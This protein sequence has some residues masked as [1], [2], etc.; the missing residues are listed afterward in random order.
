MSKS[1]HH[2]NIYTFTFLSKRAPKKPDNG[3][4]LKRHTPFWST[5]CLQ[6]HYLRQW[7]NVHGLLRQTYC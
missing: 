3:K 6:M 1:R 5:V 7:F 2:N 4:R